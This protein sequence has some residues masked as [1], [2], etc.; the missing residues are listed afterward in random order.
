MGDPFRYKETPIRIEEIFSGD[1]LKVKKALI[2][3]HLGEE[4]TREYIEHPGAAMVIPFI[5]MDQ[6][7]LVRQ[8]RFAH[9][10]SFLEFPAGR[11]DA[12][13][14]PLVTAKREL[15]EETGYLA[16]KW[17][18][19]IPIAPGIGFTNE[20]I[21]LYLAKNLSLNKN[22]TEWDAGEFLE[23]ET[24]SLKNLKS[25]VKKGEIQDVKTIIGIFYALNFL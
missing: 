9:R 5:K 21:H 6:L 16:K 12:G 13:E 3:N 2:K 17:Q 22:G 14:K 11:I 24:H 25:M 8:Y 23:L 7:L 1:F 18:Y 10:K 19:L 4:H 20:I 15:R